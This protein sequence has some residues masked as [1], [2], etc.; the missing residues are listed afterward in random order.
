ME[1][2]NPPRSGPAPHDRLLP[3]EIAIDQRMRVPLLDLKAQYETIR[4]EILASINEVFETQ[5]FILGPQVAAL[6]EEVARLCEV[7]HA[8]GVASGTDA[9]LLSLKALGAGPGDS[10]VTTP[11]TFVATAGTSAS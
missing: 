6:E 9:L 1:S 3:D 8:V 7:P 11:S 10:V 4:H 2:A 5:N